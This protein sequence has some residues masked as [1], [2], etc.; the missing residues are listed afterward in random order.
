M[1]GVVGVVGVGGVV[2]FVRFV[3]F[4]G[5]VRFVGFVG[6]ELEGVID[7]VALPRYRDAGCI[8][9]IQLVNQSVDQSIT[10]LKNQLIR[11]RGDG[12]VAVRDDRKSVM[13][14]EQS[15]WN[16]MFTTYAAWQTR[17]SRL[18]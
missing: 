17:S 2:V 14:K 1:V 15:A 10:Q 16:P 18:E 12:G 9:D 7:V 11:Q 3:G 4:V 8:S 5:F 6:F 13:G